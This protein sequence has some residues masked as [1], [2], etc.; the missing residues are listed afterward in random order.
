MINPKAFRSGKEV[1]L[2]G[3]ACL[4]LLCVLLPIGCSNLPFH[5]GVTSVTRYAISLKVAR[6]GINVVGSTTT[7]RATVPPG[8]YYTIESQGEFG[9]RAITALGDFK[10]LVTITNAKDALE[11]ARFRTSLWSYYMWPG[12]RTVEAIDQRELLSMPTYGISPGNTLGYTT[13]VFEHKYFLKYGLSEPTVK[14]MP[15]RFI[16]TRWLLVASGS[17]RR[18]QEVRETVG[19]DGSYSIVTVASQASPNFLALSERERRPWRFPMYY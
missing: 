10:G 5:H 1:P 16:I 7:V 6:K 2:Y 9:S 19:V 3:A 13:G 15:G 12:D 8:V 4:I 11:F 18:L 17:P 14:V